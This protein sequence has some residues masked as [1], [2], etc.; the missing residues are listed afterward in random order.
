MESTLQFNIAYAVSFKECRAPPQLTKL[1]QE[2]I[3]TKAGKRTRT[4]KS[5]QKP[6]WISDKENQTKWNARF[7]KILK[8]DYGN[9]DAA[10]SAIRGDERLSNLCATRIRAYVDKD[11]TLYFN[12]QTKARGA[13]YKKQS[14]TAIAGLNATIGLVKDRGNQEQVLYL[15]RLADELSLEQGRSKQAFATKRRGRD[16]DHSILHECHS[17][18]KSELQQPVTNV[19]L[20]NLVNAGYEADGKSPKEPMT[21]EQIRKNLS[22]FKRSNPF[23]RNEID[24]HFKHLI[25]DPETK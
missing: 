23:W 25:D 10:I 8:R 5:G 7:A 1:N 15:G 3:M 20:A 16:R 17:F 14:E 12:K 4:E 9:S 2:G 22:H 18:L 19:T 6:G 21:E 24:P 13:K 11:V